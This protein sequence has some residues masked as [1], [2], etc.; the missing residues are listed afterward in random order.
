MNLHVLIRLG[1]L[2]H[3]QM[4]IY[5]QEHHGCRLLKRGQRTTLFL[6]SPVYVTIVC[7]V[8]WVVVVWNN[9]SSIGV[10]RIL[11]RGVHR[12]AEGQAPSSDHTPTTKARQ[13]LRPMRCVLASIS[14]MSLSRL[15]ASKLIMTMHMLTSL[16]RRPTTFTTFCKTNTSSLKWKF[17]TNTSCKPLLETKTVDFIMKF[18]DQEQ[19]NSKPITYERPFESSKLMAQ[20]RFNVCLLIRRCTAL[21]SDWISSN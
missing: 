8:Q 10:A 18:I 16:Q 17:W 15:K 2:S 20:I 12:G 19:R 9:H 11:Y 13:I 3:P 6:F 5:A 14:S 21:N 7:F 1:C 4:L